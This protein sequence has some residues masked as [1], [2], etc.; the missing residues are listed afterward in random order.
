MAKQIIILSVQRGT[1]LG[2]TTVDHVFWFAVPVAR[3]VPK[4][5]ALSRYRDATAGDLAALADGSVI[6]EFYSMQ[7]VPGA[8]SGQIQNLLEVR[9]TARQAELAALPNPNQFYGRF[10][11]GAAW[12]NP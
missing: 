7:A 5:G 4:P 8:T 12:S 9:Y 3:R 11:D 1:G 2:D 6:E 10:W